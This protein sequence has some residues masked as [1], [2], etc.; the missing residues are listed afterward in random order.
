VGAAGCLLAPTRTRSGR[1][2]W[3]SAGTSSGSNE[4][5]PPAPPAT[6]SAEARDL[7]APPPGSTGRLLDFYRRWAKLPRGLASRIARAKRL[8]EITIDWTC[9]TPRPIAISLPLAPLVDASAA[10]LPSLSAGLAR[11]GG[12][13]VW[14]PA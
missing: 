13:E 4:P 2:C 11:G 10:P 9:T 14:G 6:S 8:G 3:Q 1:Y 12:T 7:A 5:P